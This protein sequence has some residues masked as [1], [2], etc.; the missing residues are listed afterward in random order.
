MVWY[1]IKEKVPSHEQQIRVI[2][3]KGYTNGTT[4][5]PDGDG[6]VTGLYKYDNTIMTLDGVNYDFDLWQ[7]DEEHLETRR[8]EEMDEILYRGK[9]LT[10]SDSI[11]FDGIDNNRYRFYHIACDWYEDFGSDLF[12]CSREEFTKILKETGIYEEIE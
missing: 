11:T 4:I 5:T 8:K 2:N 12:E 10:R 9:I 1:D 6:I 7:V 3:L